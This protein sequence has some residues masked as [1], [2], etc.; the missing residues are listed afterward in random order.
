MRCAYLE[1][2]QKALD[3]TPEVSPDRLPV[4]A[5]T[6]RGTVFPLDAGIDDRIALIGTGLARWHRPSIG[7][8]VVGA[9]RRPGEPPVID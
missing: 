9:D 1:S 3:N 8:T 4:T 6:Q 2:L 5:T 7:G